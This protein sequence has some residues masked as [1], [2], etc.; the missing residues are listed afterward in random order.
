[1]K[2]IAHLLH[3]MGVKIDY[4]LSLEAQKVQAARGSATDNA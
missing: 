4:L 2:L 3:F 1:M